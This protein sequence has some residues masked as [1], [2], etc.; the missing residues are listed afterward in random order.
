VDSLVRRGYAN[1]ERLPDGDGRERLV[2]LT[3]RGRAVR[4]TAIAVAGRI[5]A[6]L[7]ELLGPE[8]VAQFRKGL[9]ALVQH[10]G[11][12][13]PPL[14]AALAP[15]LLPSQPAEDTEPTGRGAAQK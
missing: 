8:G 15:L 12:A 11:D 9:T 4:S 10:A 2:R 1:R 6:E 3:D 13:P 14:V 7:D 5:T